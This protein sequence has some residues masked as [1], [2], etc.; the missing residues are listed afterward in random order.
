MGWI[1][2]EPVL[3][4]GRILFDTELCSKVAIE[5][6]VNPPRPTWD[7]AG[8]IFPLYFDDFLGEVQGRW[9]K[10]YLKKRQVLLID[11]RE[12]F[13]KF[14][15][16][17]EPVHWFKN[18]LVSISFWY[19]RPLDVIFSSEFVIRNTQEILPLN[20]NRKHYFLAN[21]GTGELKYSWGLPTIANA[22][23][24]LGE[25]I[26]EENTKIKQPLVVSSDTE[27]RVKVMERSEI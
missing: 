18:S 5:I 11:T 24:G 9:L 7:F 12:I 13:T 25:T 6:S 22:V 14:S 19:W 16:V 20:P 23:L 26:Q 1:Q 3:T 10:I 2:A 27:T 21:L 15:L 8:W 4:N 17:F